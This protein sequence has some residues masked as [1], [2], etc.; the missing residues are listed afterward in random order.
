[1]NEMIDKWMKKLTNEWI[2]LS[3]NKLTKR[4]IDKQTNSRMT[5]SKKMN[6]KK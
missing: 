5:C 2:H 1:M 6:A 3:I 4:K